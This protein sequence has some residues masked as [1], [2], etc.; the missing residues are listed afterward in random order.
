MEAFVEIGGKQFKLTQGM[1]FSVLR[2]KEEKEGNKVKFT[3]VC[4]LDGDEIITEKDKLKKI[5]VEC[6]VLG[7]EKGEKIYSFKKKPKVGY[8]KGYG[9]RDSLTMLK[10][11]DIKKKA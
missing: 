8:K 4:C 3:P 1:E 9:H 5:T 6:E 7:E 11:V 2:L 10:V